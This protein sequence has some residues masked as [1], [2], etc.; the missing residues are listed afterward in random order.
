MTFLPDVS[1]LLT[2]SLAAIL[3][4]I[5]PGPDMSLSLA[6]T[7]AGGRKAGMAAM[8]G[9]MAG[10]GV[11]TLLAALGLSAL[12]A[13]SVTAFTVLK[14]VGALYLLWMA[15]DA[16]RNGSALS[17]KEEGRA[18][19]PFWK[20][21]FMGVGI[22]LTNPKVVLFFVTFLPQFVNAADPH[23]ADK[24]LFL[25]LYFIVLT[26]PMGILMILGADKVIALLRGR[27]KLMR[28]IDYSFAGLFSVFAIKILTTAR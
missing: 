24:L 23:A 4:F 1:T 10:C 11:H 3:L 26:A 14:V 7:M 9:A 13:A 16:V 15:F 25:G 18:E 5:T 27:P 12:L 21:F 6:K 2:Y 8:L 22:N 19:I 20:T 17:V 28:G